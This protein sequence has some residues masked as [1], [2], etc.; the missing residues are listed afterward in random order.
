MLSVFVGVY[1]GVS[2][3]VGVSVWSCKEHYFCTRAFALKVSRLLT[4]VYVC[5]ITFAHK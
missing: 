4:L 3:S 1:V 5:I 2:V